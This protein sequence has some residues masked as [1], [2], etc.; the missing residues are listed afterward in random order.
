MLIRT[1]D[2]QSLVRLVDN[3]ERGVHG[4]IQSF[5]VIVGDV[6]F[7]GARDSVVVLGDALVPLELEQLCRGS[8]HRRR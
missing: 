2:R 8:A 4:L 6:L 1:S 5:D 3:I 7:S